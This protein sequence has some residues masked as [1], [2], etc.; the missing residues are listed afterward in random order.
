M[1]CRART[2]KLTNKQVPIG[3]HLTKSKAKILGGHSTR[4]RSHSKL[5]WTSFHINLRRRLWQ[6]EPK[7]WAIMWFWRHLW[8]HCD[9]QWRRTG[10]QFYSWNQ[11]T[12]TFYL[13]YY[14]T[15]LEKVQFFS[16]LWPGSNFS[17]SWSKVTV[18]V[19]CDGTRDLLSKGLNIKSLSELEP[20]LGPI[21]CFW[22]FGW[23]WPYICDLDLWN[24]DSSH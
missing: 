19:T 21:M 24:F 16:K 20:K 13:I 2:D 18:K 9:V 3:Q 14:S 4:S 22:P 6:L 11:W 5:P 8:R 7:L 10:K 17:R 23:P 15:R 1:A 12:K